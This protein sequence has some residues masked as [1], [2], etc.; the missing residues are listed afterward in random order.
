MKKDSFFAEIM[1]YVVSGYAYFVAFTLVLYMVSSF[2]TGLI[3]L[4]TGLLDIST[5]AKAILAAPETGALEL[6]LLHTIAFTIVLIKA[7]KILISYAQTRQVN[8]KFVVEMAIIAPTIEILFNIRNY[9]VEVNTLFAGF[10]FCNLVAYLFF[11]KTLK[12][13]NTD[14]EKEV[15]AHC[16]K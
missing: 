4:V 2:A 6:K 3:S 14:Y 9:S 15:A 12:V 13:V 5:S 16:K 11:Y 10:A 1:N 7:Y 8:I